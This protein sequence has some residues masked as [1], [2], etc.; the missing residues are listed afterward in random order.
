MSR[1]SPVLRTLLAG[2]S[3]ALALTALPGQAQAAPGDDADLIRRFEQLLCPPEEELASKPVG[4]ERLKALDSW[5]SMQPYDWKGGISAYR[6]T[7]NRLWP[8]NGGDLNESNRAVIC[9][10]PVAFGEAVRNGILDRKGDLKDGC[11][12]SE[13]V[14]RFWEYK[15]VALGAVEDEDWAALDKLMPNWGDPVEFIRSYHLTPC[16]ELVGRM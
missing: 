13:G 9:A 10:D 16:T 12:T 11:A 7:R 14:Q 6:E 4:T 3:A 2:C 5:Q 15:A 8:Q 1:R